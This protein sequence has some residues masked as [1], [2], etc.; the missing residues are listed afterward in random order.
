M[1]F[2]QICIK[3]FI[4]AAF[5][6]SSGPYHCTA[7][8]SFLIDLRKSFHKVYFYGADRQGYAF[9]VL[10]TVDKCDGERSYDITVC[11]LIHGCFDALSR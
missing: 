5:L 9:Y 3:L 10:V 4:A 6:E 11:F 2:A 1:T 7:T 8:A